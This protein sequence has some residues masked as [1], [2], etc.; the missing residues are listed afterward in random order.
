MRPTLAF[1]AMLFV[2]G[3][4]YEAESFEAGAARVSITP[5]RNEDLGHVS[6]GGFSAR[7]G[8]QYKGVHDDIYAR[9]LVLRQHGTTLAF[10]AL[11]RLEVPKYLRQDVAERVEG[12]G[13]KTQHLIMTATHTHSA[14]QGMTWSGTLSVPVFGR[15][16]P[17]LYGWTTRQIAK[18]V[19]K[20]LRNLGPA[21]VGSA[22]GPVEGITRNRRG[23]GPID[24]ELTV[25]EA[26]RPDG[27][28]IA[29][30]SNF[31]AHATILT[32][33]SLRISGDFPG[34]ME[35]SIE[36]KLPGAVALFCNGAL[37]D[38][39]VGD[40]PRTLKGVA[41]YGD[42][43]ANEAFALLDQCSMDASPPFAVACRTLI[44]PR[45]T[46][47][48]AF[49]KSVRRSFPLPSGL[50]NRILNDLFPER[51]LVHVVRIG[52]ALIIVI[53]G[54]A[55]AEIGLQLKAAARQLGVPHPFI[56]GLANTYCGYIPTPEGYDEG[57]YE[58]ALSVYGHEFG[59]FLIE[60]LTR[61]M[62]EA[63]WYSTA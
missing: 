56:A 33:A 27:T 49:E 25:L 10:V 36:A 50:A 20:A 21:V 37:G 59:P 5:P 19:E 55:V 24:P 9:A 30:L 57:G 48:P 17:K 3:P 11:D 34:R 63:V 53:P 13:I 6:L 45:P 14:P 47:S 23:D 12:L 43:L 58:A 44:L 61:L 52:D 38:Q 16:N 18:A 60:Q 28:P 51:A 4:P 1:I 7:H 54:E 22:Q 26:T 41:E 2:F 62:K 31:T 42:R 29:C 32:A 40:V 35:R 39:S 8:A 15:F 46:V